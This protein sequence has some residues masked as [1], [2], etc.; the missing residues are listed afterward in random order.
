LSLLEVQSA[1]RSR[2]KLKNPL[3]AKHGDQNFDG[4]IV[5]LSSQLFL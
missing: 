1:P 4:F 3:L 5:K 2:K